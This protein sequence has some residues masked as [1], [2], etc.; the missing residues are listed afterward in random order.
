MDLSGREKRILKLIAARLSDERIAEA[1]VVSK[2]TVQSHVANMK[3]KN[4][5]ATRA[6]LVAMAMRERVIDD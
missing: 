5:V 2:K 6:Q 3:R 4:A 1:P